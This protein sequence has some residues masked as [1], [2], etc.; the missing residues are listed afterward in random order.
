MKKRSLLLLLFTLFVTGTFSFTSVK[1]NFNAIVMVSAEEDEL[2]EE[3]ADAKQRVIDLACVEEYS[4]KAKEEL[5]AKISEVFQLIDDA[6]EPWT[7]DNI[8]DNFNVYLE[9]YFYEKYYPS[10]NYY[11]NSAKNEVEYFPENFNYDEKYQN[12]LDAKIEDVMNEIDS[13]TSIDEIENIV[14]SYR[15]YVEFEFYRTYRD[16]EELKQEILDYIDWT[17]EN[18]DEYSEKYQIEI[19]L[20]AT[21]SKKV[22]NSATSNSQLYREYDSYRSY[23]ESVPTH[24]EEDFDIIKQ[25]M[26][27]TLR[28]ACDIGELVLGNS[29]QVDVFHV[30]YDRAV[31][32]VLDSTSV[33]EINEIYE[34]F[35]DDV[36]D[37]IPDIRDRIE[38]AK[39][40]QSSIVPPSTKEL[41]NKNKITGLVIACSVEG[42]IIA[43]AGI[44]IVFLILKNKKKKTI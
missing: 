20:S 27:Q 28:I 41:D 6:N 24:I 14:N 26:I 30:Y 5:E 38:T 42:G 39:G 31:Q 7:I 3:K 43:F 36:D 35:L 33:D 34:Y 21:H 13:A 2:A 18:L 16:F 32:A 12:I 8:V 22:V 37:Y 23:F 25:N 9:W 4:G 11:K 17:L 44:A 15:Y 40:D 19:T 1:N 10:L 29:H